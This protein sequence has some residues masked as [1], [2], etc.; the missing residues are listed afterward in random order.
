MARTVRQFTTEQKVTLLRRH[1]IDLVPVSKLCEEVKIQPGVFYHWQKVLFDNASRAFER[2]E[3]P[4]KT[5]KLEQKVSGLEARLAR[6]DEVIAEVLEEYVK[7]K[8]ELGEL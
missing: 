5:T 8:K 1:L 6:K 7:L 3:D 2:A 4:R